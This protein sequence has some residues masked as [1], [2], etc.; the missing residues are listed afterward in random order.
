MQTLDQNDALARRLA[1]E[2]GSDFDAKF[3]KKAHWREKA[4]QEIANVGSEAAGWLS[5]FK[6][7][8]A[9]GAVGMAVISVALWL[10]FR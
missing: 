4:R 8:T 2:A 6:A 7:G 5:A 10:L 3:A 1:K 9:V